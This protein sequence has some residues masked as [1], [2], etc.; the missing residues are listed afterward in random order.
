MPTF[1]DVA[2]LRAK[3][4][5]VEDAIA[6]ARGGSSYSLGGRTLTRQ[7]LDEL[8]TE[9]SK[10]RRDLKRTQSYLEGVRDPSTAI[11]TWN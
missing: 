5:D 6:A 10:L 11:A 9:Q 1:E 3:L 7:S 8:R 4:D 2:T